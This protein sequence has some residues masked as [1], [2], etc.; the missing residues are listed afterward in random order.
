MSRRLL[1]AAV[2]AAALTVFAA[3]A[4]ARECPASVQAPSAIV[5]EVSTGEV[6]CE[7]EADAERPVG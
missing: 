6:A 7:R 3:P 1:L 4:Q 5:I 2:L